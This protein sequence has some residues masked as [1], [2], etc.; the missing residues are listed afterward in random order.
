MTSKAFA[1]MKRPA[2]NA[3]KMANDKIKKH[4]NSE[5]TDDY[6]VEKLMVDD[7]AETIERENNIEGSR[8]KFTKI[9]LNQIKMMK[10]KII[11]CEKE[12][13]IVVNKNRGSYPYNVYK[14]IKTGLYE[15]LKTHFFGIHENGEHNF[16][17]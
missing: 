8:I 1:M 14:D 7:N 2:R 13:W 15:L 10:R 9:H 12:E 11:N 4:V 5:E 3:Y 6:E 16:K 17:R